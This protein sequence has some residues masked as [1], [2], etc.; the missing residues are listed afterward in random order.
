M[1]YLKIRMVFTVRFILLL[2]FC[3][4]V[5][6]EER[7]NR[8]GVDDGL[9]NATIYSVQQD[10]SGYLWLGSTNSGLLRFDGYRFDEFAVLTAAELQQNQ[11]PDVGAVLIDK[12]DNIWAGTW[13]LGLSR[14]DAGTQTLHRYTE[15]HGLAGNQIQ[16]LMLDAQHRLWVGTTSGLSRI[17]ADDSIDNVGS[18]TEQTALAD[19]RIWSLAQTDDGTVWIG[20]SAGLHSWRADRGLGP[21]IELVNDADSLSRKNEIRA[22]RTLTCRSS[23]VEPL[24]AACSSFFS[25]PSEG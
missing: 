5:S 14:L 15:A 20:T 9:P 10:K 6:A 2:V 7:F 1:L 3:T 21:V 17:N 12:H 18:G 22:F 16:A 23:G 11:T 25:A 13:G 24:F 4:C 19:Q 8:L